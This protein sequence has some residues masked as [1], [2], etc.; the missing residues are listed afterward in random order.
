MGLFVLCLCP[1]K[2]KPNANGVL[3]LYS[4]MAPQLN[5]LPYYS[6]SL[7]LKLKDRKKNSLCCEPYVFL[8]GEAGPRVR[9][10]HVICMKFWFGDYSLDFRSFGIN[11]SAKILYGIFWWVFFWEGGSPYI[12]CGC[13]RWILLGYFD[14][15]TIKK[16]YK[17]CVMIYKIEDRIGQKIHQKELVFRSYIL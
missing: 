13:V 5:W 10:V 3:H 9:I 16:V 8:K 17:T 4:C 12:F 7:F 2:E 1:F 11:R 6:T 14:Q 15:L